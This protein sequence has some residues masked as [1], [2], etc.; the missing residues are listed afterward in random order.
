MIPCPVKWLCSKDNATPG[1]LR[2]GSE[3]TLLIPK[4]AWISRIM[5][6]NDA[7]W[8]ETLTPPK[9]NKILAFIREMQPKA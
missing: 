6:E 4:N 9:T 5:R 8:S 3:Y 2:N 7:F 1:F